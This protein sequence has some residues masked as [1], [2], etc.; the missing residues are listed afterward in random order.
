MQQGSR[1]NEGQDATRVRK[2]M[3]HD[4][5]NFAKSC[6]FQ[7]LNAFFCFLLMFT[8]NVFKTNIFEFIEPTTRSWGPEG[9]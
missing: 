3:S 7:T 1:C 8:K 5:F 9:P 6:I 4:Y 2:I